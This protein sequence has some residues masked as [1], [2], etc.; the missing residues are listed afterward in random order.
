[1]K[2]R[3]ANPYFW[4]G[5]FS[6]LILALGIEPELLTSWDALG[7]LFIDLAQNPFLI[8][9]AVVTLVTVYIDP[10][11]GGLKDSPTYVKEEEHE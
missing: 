2:K 1:M 10:S 4:I 8:G 11:T 5:V 7:E 3:L 9:L 6:T